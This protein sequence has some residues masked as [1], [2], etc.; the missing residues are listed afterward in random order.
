M[1]DPLGLS[2]GTTNLVAVRA[3]RPPVTHRAVLTLLPHATPRV[4]TPAEYPAAEPGL[5][6]G[7]FV[8]RMEQR[9]PLIAVDG[10]THRP[11]LL[12]ADAIEAMV[13]TVGAAGAQVAI[14]VP[15][16]WPPATW[17]VLQQA[18]QTR[19]AFALAPSLVSDAV[20]ALTALDSDRGVASRGVVALLDFG[21]GGTGI[22]LADAGS[23]F[24]PIDE[25][26]RY[27]PFSGNEIDQAI[28]AYILGTGA[29]GEHGDTAP[30]ATTAVEGLAQL[31]DECRR[32][33]ERLSAQA[34]TEVVAELPGYRSRTTLTR[35]Q[36]ENLIRDPLDGVVAELENMLRRNRIDW[37]DLAAVGAVGGGAHIPLVIERL[38][39]RHRVPVVTSD[40]PAVA[41]AVGAALCVT[42][43]ARATPPTAART[44]A[45]EAAGEAA[46]EATAMAAAMTATA[47]LPGNRGAGAGADSSVVDGLA[48][49]EED[50]GTGNEPVPFTR[51]PYDDGPVPGR[52]PAPA[53][54]PRHPVERRSRDRLPRLTLGLGLAALVAMIAIAGAVYTLT[55]TSRDTL[56]APPDGG[57]A[58][59]PPVPVSAPLLPAPPPASPAPAPNPDNVAPPPP[60][61][62]TDQ[63]T[64]T[65]T[66]P[67][68]TTTTTT[69]M[70]TTTTTTTTTPPTTTTTG[71]P[72]T[73]TAPLTTTAPSTATVPMT[74]EYLRLPLVPVPIPIQVPEN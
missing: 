23:G 12:L 56:P 21:G 31:T 51:E 46:G 71:P 49:S 72:T 5:V 59:P 2:I 63:P 22:T 44:A 16:Y 64:A 26:L 37:D 34:A 17:Q 38:S 32:A 18:L 4:G 55:G 6:V 42:E 62:T 29:H 15:A 1:Y 52:R 48:W 47:F 28:L 36:L 73:T 45:R 7:G 57:T 70:T 69:A 54:P 11:E 65:T 68:S 40:R 60:V 66:V 39:A 43:G 10:S 9:E 35:A 3:G 27:Q 19:P 33:K 61:T 74:T 24:A 20:A 67:Q 13:D 50:G 25:T 53:P 8:E 30:G 41:A 58:V 14:A